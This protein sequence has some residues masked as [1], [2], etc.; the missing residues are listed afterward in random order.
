MSLKI[1]EENKL[2][3]AATKK[4]A[5]TTKK[6]TTTKNK[7]AKEAPKEGGEEK[8]KEEE[9]PYDQMNDEEKEGKV[10]SFLIKMISS[11]SDA[12]I[13]SLLDN[14]S[15]GNFR[16]AVCD[17][18]KRKTLND[19]SSKEIKEISDKLHETPEFKKFN[20]Q[21]RE[22]ASRKDDNTSTEIDPDTVKY[23]ALFYDSDPEKNMLKQLEQVV[24]EIQ[25]SAVESQKHLEEVKKFVSS[26]KLNEKIT[27][28]D[29][30]AFGPFIYSDIKANKSPDDIV[31]HVEELRSGVKESFERKLRNFNKHVVLSEGMVLLTEKQRKIFLFESMCESNRYITA[32]TEHLYNEGY[33]DTYLLTEGVWDKVKSVAKGTANAV[34]DAAKA[35]TTVAK[36]VGKVAAATG[37][38]A[39]K[40]LPQKWQD[41]LKGIVKDMSE[42]ALNFMKDGGLA[43]ILKIAGIGLMIA[44]G[45]W[46]IGLIVASVML[47]EKHGK[48]IQAAMELGWTKFANSKGVISKMVF[49]IKGKKDLKYEARFYVTGLTWRV[50]NVTNQ[51]KHPSKEFAKAILTGEI[52]KKY[53]DRVKELWDK[54]FSKEKGGQIDFTSILTQA[55]N[56]KISDK[57]L[58]LITDF[59]NQYDDIIKNMQKPQIDTRTQS[60]KEIKKK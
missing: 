10:K 36:G 45:A 35:A 6:Q 52:G 46:G 32:L 3:E 9:K 42:K 54:V 53:I 20:K 55:K 14:F 43:P 17:I 5:S 21:Y 59:R 27:E 12:A 25:K 1:I 22:V 26:K 33:F 56:L 37:K 57:Q 51:L 2:V 11:G 60:T 31:K 24:T 40:A 4:P 18:Y 13:A 38:F 23:S 41:K 58:K 34:K 50:V 28:D 39:F 44:S 49:G 48:Q 8:Q 30:T 16:E 47:I 19:S 29:I 15:L 7:K